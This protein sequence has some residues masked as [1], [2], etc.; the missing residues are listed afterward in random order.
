MNK[1][2]NLGW[3][4]LDALET[5]CYSGSF[6]IKYTEI[7][8]GALQ[9]GLGVPML[10]VAPDNLGPVG[11]IGDDGRTDD[12]A[13]GNDSGN[14]ATIRDTGDDVQ[15]GSGIIIMAGYASVYAG[16]EQPYWVEYLMPGCFDQSLLDN[17]DVVSFWNHNPDHLL[18]RTG[19]STVSL[20]CD[21]HG[22]Q[23][24][25][26][27]PMKTHLGNYIAVM[28]KRGDITGASIQF[29]SMRETWDFSGD[30][31]KRYMHEVVLYEAG[32]VYQPAQPLATVGLSHMKVAQQLMS[33]NLGNHPDRRIELLGRDFT[34]KLSISGAKLT[35]LQRQI[36]IAQVDLQRRQLLCQ[37]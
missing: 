24:A 10:P 9:P 25:C 34:Q 22:L 36:L 16:V 33:A 15:P 19:S 1:R 8:D 28:C 3:L 26:D 6:K 14:V 20:K 29:M 30:P 5:R 11:V 17:P 35:D 2:T 27:L 23:Y 37:S 21:S 32:P 13:S 18:G 12:P 4:G 31:P 7:D